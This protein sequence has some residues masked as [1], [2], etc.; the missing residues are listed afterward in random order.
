[1]L[2]FK[3]GRQGWSS[4]LFVKV[5]CQ[6]WLSR[7][8]FKVGCQFLTFFTQSRSGAE[9]DQKVWKAASRADQGLMVLIDRNMDRFNK[10]N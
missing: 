1:M 10:Q 5:V 9:A 8:L 2:V 3:V 7:L 6:G 4:R